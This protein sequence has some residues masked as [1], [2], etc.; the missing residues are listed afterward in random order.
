MLLWPWCF[1]LVSSF[2]L[3]NVVVVR[4]KRQMAMHKSMKE[5]KMGDSEERREWKI[6]AKCHA[7]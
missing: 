1:L 7:L 4:R 5:S 6:V 2:F 3:E